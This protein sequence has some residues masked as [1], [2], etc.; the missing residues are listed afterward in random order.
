[1]NDEGRTKEDSG[2]ATTRESWS[3]AGR[4]R[5]GEERKIALPDFP[6]FGMHPIYPV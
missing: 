3:V 2:I 4:K 1:M 5:R 6:S